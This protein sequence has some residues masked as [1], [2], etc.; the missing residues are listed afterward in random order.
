M[1]LRGV[2][3]A[4]TC[5]ANTKPSILAATRTCLDALIHQNQLEIDAIASIFFSATPDLDSVFPAQAARDMGLVTTPLLCLNEM[6]VP[7]SLP[8]CIRILIHVNTDLT[9]AAITHVYLGDAVALRPD[10]AGI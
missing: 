7:H 5:A 4:I 3:G 8:R 6:P 1:Y 10:C 9:Q 2:R